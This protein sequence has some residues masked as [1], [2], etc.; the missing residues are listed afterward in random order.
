M[1]VMTSNQ[2]PSIWLPGNKGSNSHIAVVISTTLLFVMW[3][4]WWLLAGFHIGPK[5]LCSLVLP[6]ARPWADGPFGWAIV[7]G[8]SSCFQLAAQEQLGVV[9]GH[10]VVS[11]F[12]NNNIFPFHA[13]ATAS[14]T[15]MTYPGSLVCFFLYFVSF[16][17]LLTQFF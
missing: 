11:F 8:E 14:S 15:T 17:Y 16:F 1:D 2:P 7:R 5:K 6:L 3:I 4:M 10:F 9:L 13:T 12:G